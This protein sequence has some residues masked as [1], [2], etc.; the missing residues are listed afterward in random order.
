MPKSSHER[1]WERSSVVASRRPNNSSGTP[2]E[3]DEQVPEWMTDTWKRR[4]EA[5][6]RHRLKR[7]IRDIGAAR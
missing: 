3:K 1:R 4:V 6:A 5:E 7:N 2:K